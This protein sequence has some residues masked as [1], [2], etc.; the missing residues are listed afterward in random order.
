MLDP[1]LS[2]CIA[3]IHAAPHRIVYAFAGAGS[4]A[5]H[6]LHAVPGSSR[7]LLEARDPYAPRALAELLGAPPAQAVSP[8]TAQA[9][10]SWARKRAAALAASDWPLLGLACTAAITTDRARRGADRACIAIAAPAGLRSFELVMAKNR[11][12]RADEETLA[13]RL[14]LLA[15]ARACGTPEPTLA[16]LDEERLVEL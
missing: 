1:Q 14:V 4:L 10:A 5:L 2:A 11:R 13:S 6:W 16:L 3:A 7:T 9:M 12:S 15:L 8:A